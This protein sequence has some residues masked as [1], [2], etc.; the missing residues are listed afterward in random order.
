MVRV[1]PAQTT[2]R[3]ADSANDAVFRDPKWPIPSYIRHVKCLFLLLLT[4]VAARFC[5]RHRLGTRAPSSIGCT[6]PF[7]S[8]SG[9]SLQTREAQS[10]SAERGL[11]FGSARDAPSPVYGR[12]L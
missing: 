2:N 7:L 3:I 4:R 1:Q 11:F 10:D 6:Q 12:D 9:L 8:Y 5:P